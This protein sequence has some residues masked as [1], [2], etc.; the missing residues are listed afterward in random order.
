MQDC[1]WII[2]IMNLIRRQMQ[3]CAKEHPL[4]KTVGASRVGVGWL[5]R[6]PLL[7]EPRSFPQTSA[8]LHTSTVTHT[9]THTLQC[10]LPTWYC[11][12]FSFD[13]KCTRKNCSHPSYTWILM[14]VCQGGWNYFPS[15]VHLICHMLI[16]I[17]C[18]TTQITPEHTHTLLTSICP[19]SSCCC[20]VLSRLVDEP[21]ACKS[22]ILVT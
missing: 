11:I 2:P 17:R 15:S 21:I 16:M 12:L 8:P 7:L 18:S 10:S 22:N 4:H 13:F 9:F 6:L 1:D 19:L 14:P 20:V 5:L 3:T